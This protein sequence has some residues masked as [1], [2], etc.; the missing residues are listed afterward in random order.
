[1]TKIRSSPNCG[2]SPKMAFLKEFNIAF[3]KGDIEFLAECVTDDVE[4][5]IVGYKTIGGKENF[6]KEFKEMQS[7]KVK[8]LV[9]DQILSHGKEGATNGKMI[10]QNGTTY[11]FGD[12]YKFKTTKGQ[13]LQSITSHVIEI[14]E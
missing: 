8:E 14:T 9:I 3:A 1:M 5:A 2:N 12:F 10:M 11:A 7:E 13:K 4:W 6:V